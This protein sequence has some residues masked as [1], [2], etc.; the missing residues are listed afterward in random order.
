M[1]KIF[2]IILLAWNCSITKTDS[3]VQHATQNTQKRFSILGLGDSI[4]EGGKDFESYLYFLWEKLYMAGYE[5]DFI[6]PHASK[7]RIGLINNSGF[8]GKNAEFLEAHIDSI[9]R[10]YPADIVL[11]HTGHNHSEEEKP[12]AGIIAAQELI[13]KKIIA[14][15]PKVTIYIAKVIPSGKL[16]KYSYIPELN[17]HIE[18]MIARQKSK[19]IIL[20]DQ[21]NGFDWKKM[22]IADKVHPNQTGAEHMA[23]IWLKSLIKQLLPAV[24][25]Y[26]TKKITYKQTE[27][28]SLNLYVFKPVAKGKSKRRPCIIYFFGGGWTTGSPLQFFRECAY[29]ASKGMVA[30]TADY[31]IASVNKSSPFESVEDAKDAIRFVREHS[32]QLSVDP[33]RIVASGSS[34]GGH[35]AAATSILSTDSSK[36]NAFSCKP[37]LLL[38]YYPVIDNSPNGYGPKE[39]KDKYMEFSPLHNIKSTLPPTL[40][41]LGTGDPLVPVSTAKEFK[42]RVEEYGGSCDLIL[43]NEAGHPIFSYLKPLS[44]YFYRIRTDTDNF[45]KQHGYLQH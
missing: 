34:A 32:V 39:V 5:F 9:Y 18:L 23:S 12:I 33:D 42:K 22:T 28:A 14:I 40:L 45:L 31:R 15:N 2:L 8:S 21:A 37:N 30:I 27:T 35:L 29:Y 19:N 10:Q 11:L 1:K 13:I 3:Q 26:K 43:Y 44:D 6:G 24:N 36:N 20:V 38:L 4:T 25:T 17:K 41:I 16:P 7:C